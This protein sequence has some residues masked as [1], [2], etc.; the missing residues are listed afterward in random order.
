MGETI[1]YGIKSVL[2]AAALALWIAAIV[3]ITSTIFEFTSNTIVGEALGI[4]SM[5][6]PFNAGAVFA[7]VVA[8]FDAII[9]FVIAR[10][11]YSMVMK[12]NEAT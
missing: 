2:V 6:L 8:S 5:C 1:V 7:S 9:T 3:S 11:I 4:I 10:K 12:S